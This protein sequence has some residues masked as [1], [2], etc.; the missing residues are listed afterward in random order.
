MI[1]VLECINTGFCLLEI[2]DEI[3]DVFF[4]YP[5]RFGSL[6]S[7]F[8]SWQKINVRIAGTKKPEYYRAFFD[9]TMGV[10]II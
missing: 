10:L 1:A 4:I 3:M 5:L 9:Q 7:F 2:Q 6:F 8:S